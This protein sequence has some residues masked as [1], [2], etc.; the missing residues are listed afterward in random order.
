ML[1]DDEK[2][3]YSTSPD[4]TNKKPT[5]PKLSQKIL[6][7]MSNIGQMLVVWNFRLILRYT[8]GTARM[9]F[10]GVNSTFFRHYFACLARVGL[11]ISGT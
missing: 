11:G 3:F 7:N 8:A 2:P 1:G 6:L 9:S 4:T 10:T 5:L